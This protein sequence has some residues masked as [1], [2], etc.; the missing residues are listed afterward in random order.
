MTIIAYRINSLTLKVLNHRV[1]NFVVKELSADFRFLI[2]EDTC[3]HEDIVRDLFA[4]F[5]LASPSGV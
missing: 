4:L 1:V 3:V 5:D 2:R